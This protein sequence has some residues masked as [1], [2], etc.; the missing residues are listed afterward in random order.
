MGRRTF[1]V[2]CLAACV[3]L[4]GC[5]AGPQEAG[6]ART[7]ADDGPLAS[8][9][10]ELSSAA[11]R[12]ASRTG[13]P[14]EEA[15]AACMKAQGFEY[16]PVDPDAVPRWQ[17]DESSQGAWTR[18]YVEEYGYGLVDGVLHPGELVNRDWVDPNAA[19]L[20]ALSEEARA[21]YLSTLEGRA[22]DPVPVGEPAEVLGWAER[23]CRGAAE[24]EVLSASPTDQ[25]VLDAAQ[26][27]ADL[28]AERALADPATRSATIAWAQCLDDAG[29]PGYD[30]VTDPRSELADKLFAIVVF[31]DEGSDQAPKIRDR[32]ALEELADRELRLAM[33]DYECQLSTGYEEAFRAA[34]FRYEKEYVDAH[35]AE[36]QQLVE[37]VD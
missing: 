27:A 13:M 25:L 36:L 31:P 32:D 14:I 7:V 12:D 34:R 35:Q 33:A 5:A 24:H 17:T 8:I 19:I 20:D 2:F 28:A 15:I 18:E 16:V 6:P 10:I 1:E 37:S 11:A 9:L 21:A 29:F 30:A 3:G 26:E 4:A 23:G 22:A